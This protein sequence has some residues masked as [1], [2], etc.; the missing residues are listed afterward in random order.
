MSEQTDPKWR[1]DFPISWGTDNYITRREF[2]KF[3][4]LS[5]GATLVGNSYFVLRRRQERRSV[6]M[7]RRMFDHL[8]R[9]A[10]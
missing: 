1:T 9:D 2:T 5:S 8:L 10:H 6:Q 3:L 7:A 4:V